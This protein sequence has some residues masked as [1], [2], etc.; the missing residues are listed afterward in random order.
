MKMTDK[1]KAFISIHVGNNTVIIRKFTKS[2]KVN[3]FGLVYTFDDIVNEGW[4]YEIH[5]YKEGEE[6]ISVFRC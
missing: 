6:P 2:Q 4:K 5:Y 3:I 1:K